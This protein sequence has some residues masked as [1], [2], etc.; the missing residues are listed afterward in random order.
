MARDRVGL[1]SWEEMT[2]AEQDRL[3]EKKIWL[4]EVYA[5]W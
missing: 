2:V 1:A 5:A 3:L 4:G